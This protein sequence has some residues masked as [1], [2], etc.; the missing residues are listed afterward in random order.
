MI[1]EF[2]K[3][4]IKK[5]GYRQCYIAEKSGMNEK[6]L[7]DIING[8]SKLYFEDFINISKALK[9]EPYIFLKEYSEKQGL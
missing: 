1:E 8:R 5:S 3:D 4:K 7:S 6:K 2:I 9:V